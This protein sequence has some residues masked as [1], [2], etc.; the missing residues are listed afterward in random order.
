MMSAGDE[1]ESLIKFSFSCI[2]WF[3]KSPNGYGAIA[4]D[5]V[6]KVAD[7]SVLKHGDN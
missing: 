2:N 5:K 3:S 7:E 6:P 1:S 4:S